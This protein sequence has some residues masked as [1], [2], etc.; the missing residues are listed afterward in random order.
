MR[1]LARFAKRIWYLV[2]VSLVSL[3]LL[4]SLPVEFFT[5]RQAKHNEALRHDDQSG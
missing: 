1:S 2:F 4:L 3:A 5:P